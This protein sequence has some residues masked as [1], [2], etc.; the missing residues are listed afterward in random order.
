[1]VF[2]ACSVEIGT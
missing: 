1:M 2:A